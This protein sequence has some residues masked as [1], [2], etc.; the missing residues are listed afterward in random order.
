MFAQRLS[1]A[2]TAALMLLSINACS[3]DNGPT[4]TA[5]DAW[6]RPGPVR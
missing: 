6:R 2:A 3:R 1:I 4:L 5:P